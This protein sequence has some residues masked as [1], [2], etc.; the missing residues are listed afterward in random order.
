MAK[1]TVNASA[2]CDQTELE[3]LE[4]LAAINDQIKTLESA[5][6]VVVSKI[7]N[8]MDQRHVAAIDHD[9]KVYTLVDSQRRTVTK[10]TKDEF[11]GE[12]VA[13][14]KQHLVLTSIEP[15][16]D[17]IFAEVDAGSLSQ[18]FVDKYVKVTPIVTLRCT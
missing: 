12:L 9:G 3:A 1:T 11:I 17:G 16:L 10:A 7:K 15:D 8:F 4:K 14:G 2:I 18:D 6:Q 5:K 13:S